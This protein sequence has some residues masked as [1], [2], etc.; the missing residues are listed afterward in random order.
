MSNVEVKK[1][2]VRKSILS[3]PMIS[4]LLINESIDGC[5]IDRN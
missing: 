1:F 5:Q 3:K 2:I 4:W